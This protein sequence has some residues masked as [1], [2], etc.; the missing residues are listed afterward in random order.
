MSGRMVKFAV[1]GKVLLM[2]MEIQHMCDH[3]LTLVP[4]LD[5]GF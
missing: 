3:E 2:G 5:W 1:S 4:S